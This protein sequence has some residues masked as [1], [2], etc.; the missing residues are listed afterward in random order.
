MEKNLKFHPECFLCQKYCI[1]CF[2]TEWQ[3]DGTFCKDFKK[4]EEEDILGL[5]I[6]ILPALPEL[7]Q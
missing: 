1:E 6:D 5:P 7:L 2:D 4:Q 3:K